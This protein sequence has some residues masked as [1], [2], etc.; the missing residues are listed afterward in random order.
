MFRGSGFH[1]GLLCAGCL[2]Y[3]GTWI[4]LAS[5]SI[6]SANEAVSETGDTQPRENW[7]RYTT[8]VTVLSSV[9]TCVGLGFGY[10]L[11]GDGPM[12]VVGREVT[13]LFDRS[14]D[15]ALAVLCAGLIG[16]RINR[17]AELV[18]L[19][20]QRRERQIVKEMAEAARAISGPSLVLAALFEGADPEKLLLTSVKRF[21][22][23]SWDTLKQH[24]E[25]IIEGGTLDVV[26]PGCTDLYSLSMPCK[27]SMCDA[28]LSH[29]WRDDGNLKWNTISSWCEGFRQQ[30]NRAPTLWLDKVCIQQTCI[31][32]DLQCLPIFLAACNNLVVCCGLSYTRRLWCSVELF[33]YVSLLAWGDAVHPPPIMLPFFSNDD[34]LEAIREA[35]RSFDVSLCECSVEEDRSRIMNVM[36]RHSGGSAAFNDF[37]RDLGEAI[38]AYP[39]TQDNSEGTKL[40]P[41]QEVADDESVRSI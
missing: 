11:L 2:L 21:R 4:S 20:K 12:I 1:I 41:E 35:W 23:V 29:S 8:I 31:R 34:D 7:V 30:H 10:P 6:K 5:R 36:E 27:F 39:E 40:Q 3:T 38:Q 14:A 18:E 25:I 19:G 33:V 37:N 22:C 17:D 24:P 9:T 15:F 28:F 32:T 16:P 13:Q 26:G